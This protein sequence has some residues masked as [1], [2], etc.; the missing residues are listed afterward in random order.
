ML[1][2]QHLYHAGNLADVHKH[3]LMAW[4]LDYMGSKEKPLTYIETHAGRGLY[5][6]SAPEAIKTGEAA[7]GIA[8]MERR[9]AADHPYRRI[10]DATRARFGKTAYPGSPLIA[11]LSMRPGDALRLAEL[12]PGEYQALVTAMQ[13]FPGEIVKRDGWDHALAV[14]PPTPRRGLMLI[15]PPYEVK[16]DYERAA[17]VVAQVA[18]KWNVGVI[19]LWYPILADAPHEAML[20]ALHQDIP[21]LLV[22][23]IRFPPIRP[24]HRMMGAGMAFV[25]PPFGLAEEAVRTQRLFP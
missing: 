4:V 2:Y 5:D 25:N 1:S 3:A 8:V 18:R 16:T 11:G 7:A 9:F 22:S 23:E 17:K 19:A 6:L 21:G 13:G 12:H 20:D 24:G 15:D 10:L 14:A